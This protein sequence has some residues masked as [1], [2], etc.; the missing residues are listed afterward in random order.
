[1]INGFV[2][3]RIGSSRLPGKI[4]MLIEGRPMF[5]HV[6]YR[7]K[8][9]KSLSDVIILT[10]NNSADDVL[11]SYCIEQGIPFFR[12]SEND[13]LDRFYHA[14]KQ[15][16]AEAYARFTADCPLIDPAIV[17]RIANEYL[18]S[19]VD[20]CATSPSYT[21]PDGFGTEII[22]K[23]ALH[24]A[25][26]EA[27]TKTD[28]E[29]VTS[30]IRRNTDQFR[31]RFVE[32][33]HYH[34]YV[35][36]HMSVDDKHDLN[37]I[38]RIFQ[39]LL[40]EK[41]LFHFE[42]IVDLLKAHPEWLG[43]QSSVPINEGYF[44]SLLS[45]PDRFNPQPRPVRL[46]QSQALFRRAKQRIP[47]CTQTF[48]KGY[49]Q[50]VQGISPIFIERGEGAVVFDVDGNS[51]IDYPLGLGSISLGHNHEKVNE[52]VIA[53]LR[54]GTSHSLPH[55]LEVELA[56][57]LCDIIPCAE[58]V[59]FGKNG[60]D[61]TAGAVRVARAVTGREIILCCGYHGWQDWYIGTTY[62]NRGVPSSTKNL[63]IPFP[64]GD[65]TALERLFQQHNKEIAAV[66]MEPVGT[67][68]PPDGYLQK[69]KDIA[70]HHG[71][72]FIFDEIVT[73]FRMDLKG[74]QHYFGV[75]PD[76]AC[77]GKAM[78]NGYPISA[79]VG[80]K[81]VMEEFDRSFFSFTFGGETVSLAAAMATIDVMINE[82]VISHIW[83]LGRKLKDAYNYLSRQHKLYELTWCQGFPPRPINVF[84]NR[85]SNDDLS[86]KSLFQQE[87]IRRGIL[88]NGAPKI[89]QMTT[90]QQIEET[91]V[92]YDEAFKVLAK[93][94]MEDN[95]MKFLLGPPVEPIFRQIDY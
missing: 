17:D 41:P 69:V 23:S 68:P 67:V 26:Q 72:L 86:Y 4:M 59:R 9:A 20:Y 37:L 66:I 42:D 89:C 80:R 60:S 93:A 71:S 65:L 43:K 63:T 33:D 58:M 62:R 74:A 87:C 27:R 21:Y 18:K 88:F 64:Y 10:T 32:N 7:L 52:A 24:R 50:Y 85:D 56:E 75:I 94:Y 53:Q 36:L 39:K 2:Q 78:A 44:K 91:I 35:D 73:G 45:D 83:I 95:P 1:M 54:K 48:S 76:L 15:Y 55:R 6:W 16:P 13:V 12:G 25:Y 30:Y 40:I 84:K 8:Q 22:K 61:A 14:S 79:V 11:S 28:R 92:V 38:K 70:H 29:H 49:T 3:A 31:I 82:N 57:R 46:D 81:D 5:W 34:P 77:F 51:Y 90:D 47:S 19:E